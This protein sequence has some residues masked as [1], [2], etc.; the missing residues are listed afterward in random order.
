MSAAAKP[1]SQACERNRV[2]IL[3][4]LRALYDD[5][6]AVLEIGSGTGQHAVYFGAALPHLQ[7]HTSDL[8]ANHPGIR[9]WLDEACLPNVH[10]PLALD[11]CEPDWDAPPVQA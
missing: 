9:A 8:A 4:V 5:T 7:W 3:D 6:R 11:V 10:P 2:A 1:Y